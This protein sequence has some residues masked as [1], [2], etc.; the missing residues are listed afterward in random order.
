[1]LEDQKEYWNRVADEKDFTTPF[2]IKIFNQYIPLSAKILDFGCGYG[3]TLFNL[4]KAG[5]TNAVGIDLSENMINRGKSMHPYLNLSIYSGE[6]LPFDDNSFDAIIGLAIFT[7]IPISSR[8]EQ[9]MSELFRILKPGGYIYLNDFLL[10]KDQRNLTRYEIYQEKYHTYGIFEL[11]SGGVFRHH[12]LEYF[13]KLVE[14]FTT[15][16]STTEIF[17]TMNGNRT[18]GIFFLGQKPH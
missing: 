14:K 16:I 1:M 4:Y 15:I 5:Y 12:S 13:T 11:P 8:Q 10:T 2:R 18:N 6:R 9:T 7:C 3:R 17:K